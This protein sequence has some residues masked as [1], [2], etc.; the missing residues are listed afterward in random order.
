MDPISLKGCCAADGKCGGLDPQNLGCI[1]G[2]KLSLP[3]QA[4][5]FQPDND[6][7]A[8]IDVVCD[9]PEDC[10][11]GEMCCGHYG[12]S[13]DRFICASTCD[14]AAVT[15]P[16]VWSEICH[17]GQVCADP[18]YQCA[19]ID[20]LPDFLYRCRDTGSLLCGTTNAVMDACVEP[21]NSGPNEISCGDAKC[22]D[23]EKC[24]I[25]TP[26]E[27]YCAPKDGYCQCIT[28]SGNTDGGNADSGTNDSGL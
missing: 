15:M 1:P 9:G 13:Y 23:G 16:G 21:V 14:E 7:T 28:E 27:P 19:S 4:C 6:C 25:R 22:G 17:P 20:Y 8:I 5:Q 26:R 2:D 12:G 11:N 24:C 3:D 18:A 10:P